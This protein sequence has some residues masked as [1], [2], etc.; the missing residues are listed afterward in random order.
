MNTRTFLAALI[1]AAL[2][3]SAP[4][5]A[6]DDAPLS[7]EETA[8]LRQLL[9]KQKAISGKAPQSSTAASLASEDQKRRDLH[10]LLK[11]SWFERLSIRGYLQFRSTS[12]LEKDSHDG[13]AK[14]LIAP[15]DRTVKE[16]ESF[17]IRRGR[18]VLSGDATNHLYVYAQAEFHGS[19]GPS[20]GDSGLQMRDYYADISID[21]KKEFRFRVGQSKVPFGFV[22]LQ[23][24]Q[25]RAPLER[26]DALNSACEG[27]RDLGVYAM[28]A[29]E[30]KRKLLKSLVAN[31]LKGTG[32]YGVI[33]AGAYSGQGL[34]RSD[35][36]GDFHYIARASCP[37]ELANGQIF[38]AG[39]QGYTGKFAPPA[40]VAYRNNNAAVAAPVRDAAGLNDRRAAATFV[41][42][43]QPF[44][45]E[46]EY[47][48]GEGPELNM[49]NNTIEVQSL[50]GG[51]ALVNYRIQADGMEILPFIR[52]SYY[53]GGRK[54]AANA[55]GEKVSEL[56]IGIEFSPWKEVELT[57]MYTHSFDRTNTTDVGSGSRNAYNNLARGA[58]RLGLQCQINF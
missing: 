24:S 28:W 6:A 51:Y 21:D 9:E 20:G 52:Y 42:F 43:P 32:D 44:G 49:N 4:A 50:H 1:P 38:E 17:G 40:S 7:A 47:M 34:N 53:R 10:T 54:F 58:D 35:V 56:D 30:E 13:A 2:L 14:R 3:A 5:F 48:V 15:A 55:P 31:G 23:S 36:N 26:P 41:W 57:A 22:N 8:Q 27:E 18:V 39:I 33:T 16:S 29:P 19:V 37:F 12:L 46:A 45:F 11:D 25:N